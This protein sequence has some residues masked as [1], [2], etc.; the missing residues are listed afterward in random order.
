ML[1]WFLRPKKVKGKAKGKEIK[2]AGLTDEQKELFKSLYPD[3]IKTEPEA[4][5]KS[6][7]EPEPEKEHPNNCAVVLMIH[8]NE[9]H[10]ATEGNVDIAAG[11]LYSVMSGRM[12]IKILENL[13]TGTVYDRKCLAELVKHIQQVEPMV[14]A[15]E[16]FQQK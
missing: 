8:D 11:V 6:E 2:K 13:Q 16:I 12:D 15:S 3:L 9:F 1:D 7:S 14:K 10:V 4:K 5:A